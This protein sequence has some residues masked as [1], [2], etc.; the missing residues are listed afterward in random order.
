LLVQPKEDAAEQFSKE[1]IGPLIASTPV[2][3]AL[4]GTSKTRKSEETLLYKSFPGGFLALVGAGSPDNLARRPVR[5]VMYDE[6]DKYPITRE[7][8]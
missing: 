4:V 3:R 2:L 5:I 6:V 1:R 7:G 8:V